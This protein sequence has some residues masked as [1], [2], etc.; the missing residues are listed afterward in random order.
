MIKKIIVLIVFLLVI[1][2]STLRSYSVVFLIDESGSM[3]QTDPRNL[4]RKAISLFT[5]LS[6]VLSGDETATE[7]GIIGFSD[8]ARI[9][10][11]LTPPDRVNIDTVVK[12]LNKEGKHTDIKAALEKALDMLGTSNDNAMVILLTDGRIEVPDTVNIKT[13]LSSM[14][15]LIN[16]FD[17][18]GI[19]IHTV[20]L[21]NKVDEKL[22]KKIATSTGGEFHLV[23]KASRLPRIFGRLI[24]MQTGTMSMEFDSMEITFEVSQK[25]TPKFV[26]SVVKP[27][28]SSNIYPIL[29]D[30]HGNLVRCD[31]TDC[32]RRE[33]ES[34][35]IFTKLNPDSGVWSVKFRFPRGGASSMK[36]VLS[37]LYLQKIRV[38][39]KS[40][41]EKGYPYKDSVFFDVKLSAIDIKKPVNFDVFKVYVEIK[42]PFGDTYWLPLK[43]I[44]PDNPYEYIGFT[45]LLEHEGYYN[46]T[47]FV[48]DTVSKTKYEV[49]RNF[50][51]APVPEL[52][53]E[54]GQ[55][56]LPGKE[57]VLYVKPIK[58]IPTQFE[59][60]T[61]KKD[62]LEVTV[63]D[64][65]SGKDTLVWKGNLPDSG[66]T[67]SFVMPT[68]PGHYIVKL[69]SKMDIQYSHGTSGRPVKGKFARIVSIPVYNGLILEDID[70][71]NFLF[72]GDITS[73]SKTHR[74]KFRIVRTEGNDT[75]CLQPVRNHSFISRNGA[76]FKVF[77]EKDKVCVSG[78]KNRLVVPAKVA[79][80]S[81]AGYYSAT[82]AFKVLPYN[83]PLV[84]SYRFKRDPVSKILLHTLIFLTLVALGIYTY[85]VVTRP[86]FKGVLYYQEIAY[87]LSDYRGKKEIVIGS[88]GDIQIES[89]GIEPQHAKIVAT[90]EGDKLFPVAG[91]VEVN[92]E[93]LDDPKYGVVLRHGDEIKLAPNVVLYYEAKA[94]NKYFEDEFENEEE[95]R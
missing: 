95:F 78:S 33:T 47:I 18:K 38:Q 62:S 66:N 15:S 41:E 13:Y 40:P 76:K 14:D 9:I 58:S 80:L 91:D 89:P 5:T 84:I 70:A 86:K 53:V 71:P 32:I 50:F 31:G 57:V 19:P 28:K 6:L 59:N 82:L 29:V 60:L 83:T 75:I 67:V 44:R 74:L 34:S 39:V 22:L 61:I 81:E 93:L 55:I 56:G 36:K 77:V 72:W 24:S 16:L 37:F 20:G 2:V 21:S 64:N 30:P 17:R 69:K 27:Q 8:S 51:V 1:T 90:K 65:G 54:Y 7:L 92:D 79:S 88:H 46:A 63:H 43:R 52:K 87:P 25:N 35:V 68:K 85:K 49:Q 4:S 48:E 23:E 45:K 42:D 10:L 12:K 94:E 73:S 3:K 11:P 26:I